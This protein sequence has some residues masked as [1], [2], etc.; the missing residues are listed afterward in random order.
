MITEIRALL[1]MACVLTVVLGYAL[2]MPEF[3]YSQ[4][5]YFLNGMAF[6]ALL[7]FIVLENTGILRKK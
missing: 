4:I 1:V 7:L 6:G 3:P 2:N 5:I